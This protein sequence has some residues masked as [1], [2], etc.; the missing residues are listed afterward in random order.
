MNT[1]LVKSLAILLTVLSLFAIAPVCAL[2][3]EE[4]LPE[5][6]T[7]TTPVLV[8][9]SDSLTVA[10]GKIIQLTAVVSNVDVQPK[11]NWRSSNER[12]ATVD[13]NGVVKGK[14]EGKVTIIA[15]T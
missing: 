13:Q 6:V 3:A 8:I 5:D 1:K 2:A 11:I 15:S 14:F 12:A 4:E 7:D 9:S 10:M